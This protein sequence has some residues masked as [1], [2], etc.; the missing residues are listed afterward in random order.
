MLS[1]VNLQTCAK[2]YDPSVEKSIEKEPPSSQ[3]DTSLHIEKPPH[4]IV[5]RPPKSTLR[6]TTHNP[7]SM[8][9]QHYS[10][11]ENLAQ[12]PCTML[13]LEVL[14]TC[15]MQ[16]KGILSV[17][18]GLDPTKSNLITFDTEHS[19]P[20]LSHQLAFQIQVTIMQ[21]FIH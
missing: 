8:V 3:P 21:K 4:D 6:K 14:Q 20:R 9:A 7:N 5:I 16:Q 19:A 12:A 2:T 18:R 17:I 10:I 13:A 11:V 1:M 15:P